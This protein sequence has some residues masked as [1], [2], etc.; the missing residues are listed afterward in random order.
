MSLHAGESLA[1]G[2][3]TWYL[4]IFISINRDT[5]IIQTKLVNTMT[6]NNYIT[7]IIS[8]PYDIR[9]VP[10]L[11]NCKKYKR[12]VAVESNQEFI[13]AKYLLYKAVNNLNDIW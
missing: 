4:L 11:P 5:S 9:A 8:F 12:T 6:L 13:G 2:E 1:Y 10:F 7:T 3:T